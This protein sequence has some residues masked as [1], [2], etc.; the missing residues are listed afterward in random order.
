MPS[1]YAESERPAL[2]T[3]Q[4]LGW[5][6]VDQQRTTWLDPR[7]TESSAVLESRLRAAVERLNPW[8]N[9]NNLNKAVR[10]IQ[11]VA[12][13]S[14][15]DEN[16]Q[17]HEKLVRH[18]SVKQDLG[19]GLKHQTVKYI[20]YENP[21][22]N[23]FFALNQF[24][25]EG[26]IEV[27][28]P[29]IVLFV[30]GI[31]LGVVE[32]KAPTIAEPRSEALEQLQRYQNER[33]ETGKEGAEEL[34]RY[35]Q[36]SVATWYEGAVM[37]TY[38]TPKGQY[39][40]WRDPYPLEDEDIADLLGVDY[41]S[42]QHRMLYALFEPERLLDQLRHFTVF[43]TKQS[44]A[45][46]LVARYQQYR[47][48]EKALE[49]IEHRSRREAQGGVVWHTQGSGKSLTMLFLGLK[50]RRAKPDPTLL[51]VTDRTALDDQIH[52]TF[53]RCGFPNPKKAEDIDDLREKLKTNAGETITTLI[54]KFQLHE[55]EE[56][57]FPVLSRDD[58]IYVMVDEAHRTQYKK[59][60]NNMRTALPNAYYVGFTGTPIEKDEKNTRRTF[61]NYIDT[62][63][64]DQSL[65]DDTTVEILYQG[66]LADIHL[67]G[68]N[69]DRIFDRVFQD[70][71]DEEKAE[72]Q[73]RYAQER[74][75]A[76]AEARI[77]EVTLDIVEHFENEI[78]R[79][80]KGMVVTTSKRAAIRYK[81][82]LDA[83]NGPESRVVISHG[84]NDPEEVKEWAPSDTE[85]SKYKEEFV[86]PNGEVELLVVCDMLLTGFDAPVAQVMYLDKPLRE[87]NLLQAIARVN[88]PFP[89]K[90]H[91]LI[92]DY[93]GISDDLKTAL[94]MF[95]DD[96]V[97]HAMVPLSDKKPELEAAH[98]KAVSFFDDIE[99]MEACLQTLEP[100][101]T[102]IEFKNA[103]KR[104]SQLMD[105]VLPDPMANPYKSD[106]DRLSEIYARA[107]QRFRDDSMNL[108]GCG[109][110][111]RELIQK[112]I[113]SKGI[114][115]LNDD[116]VSIMDEGEFGAK[117]DSLEDDEARASEMRHAV[118]HE[119]SVRFDEDP[120]QYGSLQE[121]VEELIEKYKQKR[122]S[123]REIIE[124]LRK[125]LDEMR[126]RDQQARS[127][128]LADETE[129]SFYHA[130]E[131]VLE[132][133]DRTV[134]QEA[135]VD[136][137][138]DIV[139]EVE[140]VASVVEWQQ[141][142]SLQQK[143][144]KKVKL[145]LIQADVSMSDSE[146]TQLTNRIVELAR[147]HY[148]P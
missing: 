30:N 10:E 53:K 5:E 66:R 106:L 4:Q 47:A 80:F 109:E 85:L 92:V 135:L 133:E 63:T 16:E 51:L 33:T 123:D 84:H 18:T 12:G 101:D 60:A 134:D 59:L 121:R 81:K 24:R 28:K 73:K 99:D 132:T 36:F 144:R 26:P 100:E 110:K 86:D 105:I 143:L 113:R 97:K 56:G 61:G 68:A 11:Q 50:L 114:D 112:H 102:R 71:T 83:L 32:C 39:K 78:A 35:N 34:F 9:E 58:D 138:G 69:L 82:K 76:E 136:L 70:R 103:Y 120:V 27:I 89:E 147:A 117:I 1:E 54:Q 122:M 7:E 111:V 74:D 48:V 72:I 96:D 62:Y 129:L 125:V 17:I 137:T 67:E 128:G 29:D 126:S 31:P 141:K 15:M 41:L 145:R 64:I 119:I 146:R 45:V 37:G 6:V 90:N 88:R 91:G 8:L 131:D 148:K 95:S 139:A 19:H 93:Y 14:T 42:P 87:H 130:L 140:D 104:F 142:V 98:R 13:T 46:K 116:P 79:P 75:L 21:G 52:A 115:V 23:D 3:L 57:D 49:R 107:K 40:P 44:G 127:K 55:D 20:D 118:K 65:E 25:V 77:E 94:A 124:E 22:N 2:N 108:E 38:G 43:E